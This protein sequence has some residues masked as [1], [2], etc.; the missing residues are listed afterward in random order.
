MSQSVQQTTSQKI[1]A[2]MGRLMAA[3]QAEYKE[4]HYFGPNL[5]IKEVTLPAGTVII[6][7]PHKL[8]HMCILLQGRMIIVKEDGEKVELVAPMTFI[9]SKGRKVAY[10]IETV[11]FQNVYST[12]ETDIEKLEN[13]CVENTQPL[14][15]EEK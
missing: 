4:N 7:K 2:L 9:G 15:E 8:E 5:Y 1:E 3:P 12:E 6:G 14:L 13:M 11:V 10:I